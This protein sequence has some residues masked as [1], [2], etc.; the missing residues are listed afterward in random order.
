MD[1]KPEQ[2]PADPAWRQRDG[3][4]VSCKEKL[5]VLGENLGEIETIIQEAFE[6]AALMDVDEAQ[7]RQ[8]LHDLI[9]ALDTPYS[10][11]Q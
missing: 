4:P 7:F 2:K 1:R 6:D 11:K 8:V 10:K 9:T 3:E 5:A